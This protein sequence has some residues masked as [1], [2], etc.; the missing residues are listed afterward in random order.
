MLLVTVLAAAVLL[1]SGQRRAALPRAATGL[2]TTLPI[3]WNEERDLAAALRPDQQAHWAKAV[4]AGGGAIVPLD[5]LAAPG[6]AGPL[7]AVTRLVLAQPR[8]LSPDENVALDAWVR[9]GGRALVLADPALTEESA[10]ALGDRRRPQAVALLS[11]ILGHWGLDLSFDVAQTFGERTVAADRI[12]LPVNLAGRL[13][14]R[15]G[16]ACRLSGEAVIAVCAIGRGRA[17]VVAD[18]AVLERNDQAGARAAAF[19]ALL[20]TAFAAR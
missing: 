15:K 18:A 14:V 13:E 1:T 20:D 16:A 8:P 3:L 12:A 19:G 10:F 17:T 5:T 6:A 2:F 9:A 7:A 4:I 11:P